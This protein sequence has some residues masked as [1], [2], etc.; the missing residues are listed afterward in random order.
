[1]KIE[2]MYTGCLAHGAY[3]LQSASEAA[4]VDPLR[5]VQPYLDRARQDGAT[6]KYVLE[7]HFHAD[8]VS[9]HQ[10]L[11][12]KTGATIVFGPTARPGFAAHIAA[13]GEVL[14]VGR[15]TLEVLHTPGHTRE[16]V[17][18]LVR[19]EAGRPAALFSGDTLLLGDVGR[20][21]LAQQATGLS[22][23]ELAGLLFDSLRTKIMPLPDAVTVYPGHGAGS[24]CGQRMSPDTVD[25]LGHQKS[26][27]YALR[28]DMSRAEFIRE[29]T[30][31]LLPPPG[32]FP[33]NVR[34]N[35]EGS[36]DFDLVLR[37]GLTPLGPQAFAREAVARAALILDT[38]P[39]GVFT[40]GFIPGSLNIGLDGSFAPWVGALVPGV[41]QPLLLVTAPG[42]QVETVTRL[43][44]IGYDNV[45]GY[46]VGGIAAWQRAGKPLDAIE[47]ISAAEFARRQRTG[48]AAVVV[49]VRRAGEVAASTLPRA[50]H[51]PLESLGQRQHEIPRSGAVYVYCAGGYR[52]MVAASMLRARGWRN[53][54]NIAGGYQAL[55]AVAELP[56]E[57]AHLA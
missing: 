36:E 23:E 31:G 1:M 35:Q 19:D 57:P 17:C 4:V 13:D 25:T 48:P 14:R 30:A 7:T 55:R 32:Y 46:L 21:D 37:Q 27:N 44:R 51:I 12:R 41:G 8:F 18:Y 5:E 28:A 39:A 3:Y 54:V 9:G 10:A 11:A 16:S 24:A 15:V 49:D 43:A 40:L 42:C 53:V 26:T 2:Q 22:R 20:P 29:V 56:L 34:L 33:D 38:R 50:L 52:S 45:L 6:L 47:S